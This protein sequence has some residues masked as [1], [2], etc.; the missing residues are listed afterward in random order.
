MGRDIDNSEKVRRK[1]RR[2]LGRFARAI[3]VRRI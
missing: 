1:R 2:R 3:D